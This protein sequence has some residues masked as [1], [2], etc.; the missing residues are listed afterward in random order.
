MRR[1]QDARRQ[2]APGVGPAGPSTDPLVPHVSCLPRPRGSLDA[3]PHSGAD[4]RRPARS[5]YASAPSWA[6]PTHCGP[7]LPTRAR[8]VAGVPRGATVCRQ[9]YRS[10]DDGVVDPGSSGMTSGATV[11]VEP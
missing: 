7:G 9:S 8:S 2:P 3:P 11:K 6:E 10:P 5:C 1:E 4:P